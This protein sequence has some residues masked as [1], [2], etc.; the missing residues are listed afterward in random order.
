MAK[1][2]KRAVEIPG[3]VKVV[4]EGSMCTVTGPKG[5]ISRSLWYPGIIIELVDNQ[6]TVDSPNPR[7]KQQAMIGTIS[8]HINNM[9]RGVTVG[10]SYTMKMVYSHFPIQLKVEGGALNIGNFLGEKKPRKARI[11]GE[12]KVDV[13]GDEVVVTGINIE[14]VGQTAANIQQATKIKR[15]DPRV[16]QDGIYVVEKAR[17]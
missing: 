14:D 6:I 3:E 15:F 7:K 5:T 8:S 13:K 1:E 10:F 11:M 16:F 12:T 9:V 2:I 4:M 17:A